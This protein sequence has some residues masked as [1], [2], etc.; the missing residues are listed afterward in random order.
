MIVK[1][2]DS[3]VPSI[4]LVPVV[5]ELLEVFSHDLLGIPPEWEIDFGIDLLQDT[6]P[7]SIPP[8]RIAPTEL[9]ELKAQLE[10]LLDK[11]FIQQIGR[12]HV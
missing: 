1:D 8:Y 10:D 7:I 3:K 12:A 6:Y 4:E 5:R 9:K 2:L 11:G